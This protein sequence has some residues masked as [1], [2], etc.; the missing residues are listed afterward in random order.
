MRKRLLKSLLRKKEKRRKNKM[1]VLKINDVK[2]MRREEREEKLKE[3]QIELIKKTAP[4]GRGGKIKNKE[5]KKAIAR[6]LT[7]HHAQKT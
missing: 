2:G 5:I 3:L 6:I 1:A 4:L 7:L